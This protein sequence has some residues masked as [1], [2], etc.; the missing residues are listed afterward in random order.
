[1]MPGK[2]WFAA[3]N[4]FADYTEQEFQSLLGHRPMR[5][6]SGASNSLL[7]LQPRN[8]AFAVS[9][10]WRQNITKDAMDQGGCG[11][12]WAVASVGALESHAVIKFGQSSDVSFEQLVDCVQNPREC[13]GTGGCSGATAELAL[14]YV[15]EHGIVKK[16]DYQN[17]YMSGGSGHCNT[18]SAAAAYTTSGF[19]R[20]PENDVEPLLAAISNHGPVVVSADAS[21]W[22]MYSQGIFDSCGKDA[23][24]NHAILAM[25]YGHD[26]ELDKPYILIRNSWGK[27]WGENGFIRLLRHTGEDQY[28]GT[29]RKP[30][31]GVACKGDPD[32]MAVCGM[33][34]ILADSAYPT[35]LQAVQL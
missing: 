23:T 29:D 19:V 11:S 33:C 12:C 4:K 21:D 10:D 1:M 13:G 30:L 27:G 28:C 34:G 25:G 8:E 2:L 9:V 14:E 26:K 18:P 3:V 32:T 22:S 24:L 17:G 35:G 15:K 31:D 20:L 6:R 5:Q 16:S 7:Q